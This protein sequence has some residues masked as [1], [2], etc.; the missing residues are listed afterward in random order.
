MRVWLIPATANVGFTQDT[1]PAD[2]L[3]ILSSQAFI[4]AYDEARLEHLLFCAI[5]VLELANAH[6]PNNLRIGLSLTRLYRLAGCGTLALGHFANSLKPKT[7]AYTKGAHHALERAST[8]YFAPVYTDSEEEEQ[9]YISAR[10][11]EFQVAAEYFMVC[12]YMLACI[13]GLSLTN[14]IQRQHEDMIKSVRA[15]RTWSNSML[16]H[17]YRPPNTWYYVFAQIVSALYAIHQLTTDG[18]RRTHAIL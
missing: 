9:S 2:D 8:F 10:G 11:D 7:P 14:D 18:S 4:A 12:L 5:A 6:S 1:H 17:L 15:L 3:A 16:T 13:V